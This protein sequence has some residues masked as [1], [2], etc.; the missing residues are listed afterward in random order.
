MRTDSTKLKRWG[1]WVA[2]FIGF[3]LAGVAARAVSG[4]IDTATAAAVGGLVGG[5]VLGAAQTY[6]G[7]IDNGDRV[8]WTSA[9]AGGLAIGLTA[10][11]GV[12]GYRTDTTSLVVM[13]AI[14]GALVGIAQAVSIPM[15]RIDRVL[16]AVLTPALWGGGWW[17]TSQV[18]VDAH[19]QHAVFGSSGALA[20][21]AAAGVLYALRGRPTGPAVALAGG[22]S[23]RVAA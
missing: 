20:V 12:V 16:W 19:R 18:I 13:G 22:A 8:R 23:D 10:G 15:R 7:G 6:I 9:T 17:I 14:T 11:A 4:N 1:R 5:L 3:P 21:S 2:T